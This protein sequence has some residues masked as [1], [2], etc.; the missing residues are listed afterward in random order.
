MDE[1]IEKETD[2]R[3]I[4]LGK[5][6]ERHLFDQQ[7]R[8]DLSL[9][10]DGNYGEILR[11]FL[12]HFRNVDRFSNL[13]RVAQQRIIAIEGTSLGPGFDNRFLPLH[14]TDGHTGNGKALFDQNEKAL[15]SIRFRF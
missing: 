5:C 12:R 7:Q 4:V 1:K 3:Q 6:H 13:K 9:L 10:H 2:R 14:R 8:F 15:P 11:L